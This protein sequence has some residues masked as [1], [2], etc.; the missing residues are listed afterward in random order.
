MP[1]AGS[2]LVWE[3]GCFAIVSVEIQAMAKLTRYEK[4]A[5]EALSKCRLDD[6]AEIEFVNGMMNKVTAEELERV[7]HTQRA[8]IWSLLSQHK[9]E[10]YDLTLLE[11][12]EQIEVYRDSIAYVVRSEC[13]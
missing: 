3:S 9:D 10:I 2:G 13:Q 6:E 5:L 8:E 12:L 4:L 1:F 7:S 11:I